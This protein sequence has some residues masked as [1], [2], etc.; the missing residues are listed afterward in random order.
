M[1][2]TATGDRYTLFVARADGAPPTAFHFEEWGAIGCFYWIDRDLGYA[3]NGPKDRERL[4][5]IATKV[6]EQL[7]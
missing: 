7:S 1:Y 2:E 6:Y 3:L 4:M 5:T